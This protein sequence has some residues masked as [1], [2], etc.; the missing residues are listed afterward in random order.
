MRLVNRDEVTLNS[1]V[2]I[3]G[4]G[5][6]IAI[7]LADGIEK[8]HDVICDI[9]NYIQLKPYEEESGDKMKVLFSKVR[10][11]DLE[12]ILTE[13]YNAEIQSGYTKETNLL[14]VPDLSVT[15]SKIEKARKDGKVIMSIEDARKKYI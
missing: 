4:I 8:Y 2:N 14:I 12:K 3:N 15:S 13:K 6:K 10:D 5:D 9:M 7:K 11:R 1:L